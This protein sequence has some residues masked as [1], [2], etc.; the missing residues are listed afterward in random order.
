MR[1]PFKFT[2]WKGVLAVIWILGIIATIVRFSK[3][4]GASTNLSNQFPWGLWIGFDIL[5]G[6]GLAA[7]GFT[8]AAIVYIFHIK[9]FYPIL[10]PTILT[11]FLGYIMMIA[12]LLFDLGQPWRIWH[13]LIYWNPHSVLFEVGWCVMLYTTVLALEFSPIA[14]ERLGWGKPKKWITQVTIPLVIAGVILSTLHQSSL[15]SLYL[16]MPE[17][18]HPLWY[19][20]IIPFLFFL[21]AVAAGCAMVIF[22]SHLSFRAFGHRLKLDL[23]ADL[24]RVMLVTL[25]VYA[26]LRIQDFSGRGVWAHIF[27]NRIETQLFW[28][29]ALIGVIAPIILLSIKRIRLSARGL[30]YASIC[31]IT[32]FMLNRLNVTVTGMEA[33]SGVHYFPSWM[34]ISITL[35][36][37]ATGFFVFSLAVRYLPVFHHP[38]ANSRPEKVTISQ[39]LFE[40]EVH[41]KA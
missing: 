40:T 16:I 27:E 11:A 28:L 15:G 23:L 21:S 9:R 29:E 35:A 7:G 19:S 30:Y 17:K 24:G 26:I 34:E 32:G 3:G 20:P 18:L 12:G 5:C 13:L 33:S 10:R 38:E 6:I 37:V 1:L 8:I 14:F 2:F 39:E 31:T 41:P 36:I 4:L 25:V 22:E